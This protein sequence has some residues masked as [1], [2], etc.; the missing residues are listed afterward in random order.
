MFT[1]KSV[2]AFLKGPHVG[3]VLAIALSLWGGFL[4]VGPPIDLSASDRVVWAAWVVFGAFVSAGYTVFRLTTENRRLKDRLAPKV[5]VVHEQGKQPEYVREANLGNGVTERRHMV[6]IVNDSGAKI[7]RIRVMPE[8]FEPY[9]Q[10]VTWLDSSFH[11]V[12]SQ[13]NLDGWFDLSVGDGRPTRYVEIFRELHGVPG[14]TGSVITYLY[15]SSGLNKLNRYVAGD[16]VAVELR[17]EG[18]MAPYRLKLVA[19]RDYLGWYEVFFGDLIVQTMSEG[20]GAA[21]TPL[22]LTLLTSDTAV[23]PSSPAA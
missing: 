13:S 18:D 15:D 9:V 12:R 6:G 7:L 21:Y 22:T 8:R 2:G 16:W 1:L 5:H 14:T 23:P 20:G 17:V 4:F 10:G 19:R 11:P 3:S